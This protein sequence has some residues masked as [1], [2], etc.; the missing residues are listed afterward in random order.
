MES[1]RVACLYSCPRKKLLILTLNL[2]KASYKT[3]LVGQILEEHPASFVSI[4]MCN[5]VSRV[6][7]PTSER[8]SI[9]QI[10][11]FT[12]KSHTG[13]LLFKYDSSEFG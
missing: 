12:V 3:S 1:Q 11:V 10:I 7:Q 13:I 9:V 6:Y 2:K 4:L 8:E 5:L